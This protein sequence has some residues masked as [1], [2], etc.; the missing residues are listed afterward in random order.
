MF[1]EQNIHESTIAVNRFLISYAKVADRHPEFIEFN[2]RRGHV[3]LAA[4]ESHLQEHEFFAAGRYTIADIA[5]YGYTHVAHEGNFDL[6]GYPAIRSWLDRVC[7]QPGH[8]PMT[9]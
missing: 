6:G 5:L 1:F 9:R 3:A 8:L 2:H 4:M 7:S